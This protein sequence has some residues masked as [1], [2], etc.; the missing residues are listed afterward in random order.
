MNAAED[1]YIPLKIRFLG[2]WE[3]KDPAILMRQY[4]AA[5]NVN[6]PTQADVAP[7]AGANAGAAPDLD[8]MGSIL[9]AVWGEGFATPGGADAILALAR[10]AALEEGASVLHL[11]AGLGGGS[12]AVAAEWGVK[13]EG[14]EADAKIAKDGAEWLK[15]KKTKETV[16]VSTFMPQNA[17]LKV[18]TYKCVLAQE[19]FFD[20]MAKQTLLEKVWNSLQEDS[21]LLFTDLVYATAEAAEDPGIQA[22][23][24]GE[25]HLPDP[26]TMAQYSEVLSGFGFV[27]QESEDDTDVYLDLI[28]TNWLRFVDSLEGRNPDREFVDNMMRDAQKW[29][30]RMKALKSGHLRYYRVH[31]YRPFD[32]DLK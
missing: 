20:L 23:C 15:A 30:G 24:E 28:R 32:K 9:E 10:P 3:G 5:G 31:A 25:A 4:Q 7:P 26:W 12:Q 21:H 11:G 2:W 13:V 18:N 19:T 6:A 17:R 22:W 16:S 27:M 1:S 29:H 8:P 14:L